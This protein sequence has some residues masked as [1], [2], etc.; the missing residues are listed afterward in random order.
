MEY[1]HA[2]LL[3]E[4]DLRKVF[5]IFSRNY[6]LFIA[7][8]AFSA[9]VAFLVNFLSVPSY[10]IS[11]SLLIRE[12]KNHETARDINDFLN[13][14]LFS[15]NQNFQ[16]ELWII[17]SSPIFDQAIKNLDLTV[18][19]LKKEGLMYREAYHEVPFKVT[20]LQKHPQ[21]VGVKFKLVF[22]DDGSF[23]LSAS[24]RKVVIYRFDIEK[25]V[26]KKS[27]WSF[28]TTGT[29]GELLENDDLAIMIEKSSIAE[30]EENHGSAFAF[31]L[32]PV[33]KLRDNFKNNI[34]F[35]VTDKTATVVEISMKAESLQKGID[36]INELM[37]VY[38][39]QNL[40]R[41]NHMASIT[42]NYIEKQLYEIS[43]SLNRTEDHLQNFKSSNQLLNISEQ[44]NGISKQYVE[45]QNKLAELISR[46][47]YYD[48]VSNYIGNNESF[49]NMIVPASLG[50]QDPLLNSL[51]AELIAA[52]SQQSNL[53]GNNQERN[54]L[55]QK[56]G[57][58]IENIKKTIIENIAAVSTATAVS[59]DDMNKRI[60]EIET[61]IG[62]LPMTQRLL[63]NIERK[64]RLN[65]AIYN[66]L[67]E[68][69][70]EAKIT[71]A[72]NLPDD[73]VVEPAKMVGLKPVSPDKLLNYIIALIAGILLPFTYLATMRIFRNN[74]EDQEDIEELSNHPVLGKI[75]HST[76]GKAPVMLEKP[77]SDIAESFRAL[78]T[79]IDFHLQGGLNKIILITSCM[80][81][82][83]KSFIALNL[84]MSYAQLSR[85]TVIVNF[86]LR[87]PETYFNT[88]E[89]PGKGVSSYLIDRF[90]LDEIIK[91]S[92][93]ENL[94]YINAGPLP[95]NPVELLALKKVTSLL[96]NLKNRYEIVILDSAPLAQVADSYLLVGKADLIVVVVRQNQTSKKALGIITRN[97]K[98]KDIRNT[99]FVL[100]D[101]KL[102]DDQIGYGYGYDS[103]K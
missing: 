24:S 19:Y 86:D 1:Q 85:K 44:A 82:E 96:E 78:R 18:T 79:N 56:L 102:R 71:Q 84:A 46:K 8:L 73:L 38:S 83:G 20:Y 57:I 45:L 29:F 100:N 34:K 53:I 11:S 87:K 17:K 9:F 52:Q 58:Q 48:Y 33:A 30:G 103:R 93:N 66:Y 43:D 39:E 7:C 62:R 10:Q 65:D 91:V 2:Q 22:N 60:K 4:K 90:E 16:N 41:K 37:E 6:K 49:S 68:K 26:T 5:K 74:I 81:K 75:L 47:R 15:K 42:I 94:D 63:G 3:E 25:V 31:Q 77:D 23:N 92:V 61:E 70:A 27:T 80:E 14:S 54:P 28:S 89:E 40:E 88:P 13:S 67:L 12:E 36:L 35:N 55:V 21:P 64:F 51:M 76:K 59:I 95:P 50:I 97:L 98:Q 72:S 32:Q 101:N 69:H 99:C